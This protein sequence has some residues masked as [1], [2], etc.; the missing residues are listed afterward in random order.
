MMTKSSIFWVEYPFN[1]KVKMKVSL[2]K[3]SVKINQ[4]ICVSIRLKFMLLLYTSNLPI[5]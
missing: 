1:M 4:K 5:K 2:K 3:Q